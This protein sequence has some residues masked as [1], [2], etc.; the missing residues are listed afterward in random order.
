ME[1]MRTPIRRIRRPLHR[2]ARGA[3]FVEAI[4][5]SVALTAVVATG[6]ALFE[7]WGRATRRFDER[8]QAFAS[9]L[10]GCGRKTDFA[11]EA[12]LGWR[13]F[14]PQAFV[15]RTLPGRALL[16]PRAPQ[17]DPER[18]SVACNAVGFLDPGELRRLQRDVARQLWRSSK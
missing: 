14:D 16:A 5:A 8:A 11:A 1:V 4:L 7:G 12:A 13:T 6:L 17:G 15:I 3:V 18:E 9:A 10:A 2:S